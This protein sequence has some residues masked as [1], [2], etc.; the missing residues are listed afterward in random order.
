[1]VTVRRGVWVRIDGGALAEAEMV[2]VSELSTK[3]KHPR[4]GK[5]GL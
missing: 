3:M 2:P 5:R 4:L 1:M